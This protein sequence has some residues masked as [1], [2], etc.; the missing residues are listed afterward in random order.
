MYI[1]IFIKSSLASNIL[2]KQC[3]NE[4]DVGSALDHFQEEAYNFF[5]R[6]DFRVYFKCF[7]TQIYLWKWQN[8]FKYPGN[9][10]EVLVPPGIFSKQL[11]SKQI[12]TLGNFHPKGNRWDSSKNTQRSGWCHCEACLNNFW[13]ILGIWRGPSWKLANLVP[14]FKKGKKYDPGNYRPMSL[15]SAAGKIMKKSIRGDT[16]TLLQTMQSVVTAS[17][18]SWVE[19]VA[20]QSC[21]P[22]MIGVSD[23]M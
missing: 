19:S 17:A 23:T 11:S 14:V 8:D 20:C 22:Y 4:L 3:I 18:A 16:E 6:S 1:S 21:C 13:T 15:T 10:D 12:K 7:S 2:L 5:E 9:T